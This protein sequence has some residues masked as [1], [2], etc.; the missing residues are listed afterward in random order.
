MNL[1]LEGIIPIA[2]GL[3]ASLIGYGIV[4]IKPEALE[5][6][7]L[8]HLKWLGPFVVVFGLMLLF[9]VL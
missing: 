1:N 5:Q 6:K 7:W 8:S 3:L 9:Q 2:G 4:Q